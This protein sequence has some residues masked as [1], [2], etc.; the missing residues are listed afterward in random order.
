MR[1]IRGQ[2]RILTQPSHVSPT[3]KWKEKKG[4]NAFSDVTRFEVIPAIKCVWAAKVSE[5]IKMAVKAKS[6]RERKVTNS[7]R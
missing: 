2:L 6:K 7:K 5:E 1:E 4:K 3:E